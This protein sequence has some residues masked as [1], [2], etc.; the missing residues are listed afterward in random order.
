MRM[1][2]WEDEDVKQGDIRTHFTVYMYEILKTKETKAIEQI[3]I[4]LVVCQKYILKSIQRQIV[5]CS[6]SE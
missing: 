2:C 3:V 6:K 5:S 4:E 1:K